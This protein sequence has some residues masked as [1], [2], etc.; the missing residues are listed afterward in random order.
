[1]EH[2]SRST[3]QEVIMKVNSATTQTPPEW[4]GH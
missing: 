3:D 1:M 2:R 4:E